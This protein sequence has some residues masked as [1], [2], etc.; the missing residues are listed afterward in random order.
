MKFVQGIMK[1][2]DDTTPS[3]SSVKSV[4][5]PGFVPPVKVYIYNHKQ[6]CNYNNIIHLMQ[7]YSKSGTP[8]YVN[9]PSTILKKCLGNPLIACSLHRYPVESTEW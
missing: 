5:I 1:S 4:D 9:L 7:F 3:I 6:H 2:L 8:F